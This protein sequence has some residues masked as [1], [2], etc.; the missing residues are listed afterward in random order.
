MADPVAYFTLDEHVVDLSEEMFLAVY[1][2]QSTRSVETVK[3]SPQVLLVIKKAHAFAKSWFPNLGGLP[4]TNVDPGN[5]SDLVRLAALEVA[6][7]FAYQRRPE[8][9]RTYGCFPGGAMWNG[10][11]AL[12]ERI[13]AGTQRIASDDHPVKS[14]EPNQGATVGQDGPKALVVSDPVDNPNQGDW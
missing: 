1:D 2:D 7:C 14:P 9:T 3:A 10:M 13:Q 6:K 5:M 4:A 11:I 12:F 8:A